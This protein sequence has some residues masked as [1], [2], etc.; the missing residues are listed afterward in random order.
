MV[1]VCVWSRTWQ[2][3]PGMEDKPSTHTRDQTAANRNAL[4]LTR[5]AQVPLPFFAMPSASA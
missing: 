5:G 1:C 4:D 2:R 3:R